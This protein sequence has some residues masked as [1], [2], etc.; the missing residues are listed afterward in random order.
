MEENRLPLKQLSPISGHEDRL[1]K[2]VKFKDSYE[3]P[4]EAGKGACSF[5]ESVSKGLDKHE[6]MVDWVDSEERELGVG[7]VII[8][9][10]SVI[11]SVMISQ[12]LQ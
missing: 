9:R 12:S 5:R 1:S 8:D 4:L 6:K 2:K 11:P 10:S 3:D 7:N